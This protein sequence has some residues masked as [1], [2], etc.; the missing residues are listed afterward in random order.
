VV[1]S[2]IQR[3]GVAV[4]EAGHAVIALRENMGI[5]EVEAGASEG[6]CLVDCST[7]NLGEQETH[8]RLIIVTIAG[9]LAQSQL[10]RLSCAAPQWKTDD[11]IISE[12]VKVILS[13]RIKAMTARNPTGI[14]QIQKEVCGPDI[15]EAATQQ[16]DANIVPI[17]RVAQ[18]LLEHGKMSG[19][20]VRAISDDESAPVLRD[21]VPLQSL[22]EL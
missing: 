1:S 2:L 12:A 8:R 19:D 16:Y 18:F 17:R 10:R 4:H 21:I 11:V 14:I 6:I 22:Y 20:Q 15:L 3:E 9:R 7:A 13:E 5:F